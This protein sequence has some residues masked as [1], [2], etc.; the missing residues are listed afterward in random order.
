M[1]RNKS[2]EEKGM[3]RTKGEKTKSFN[4]GGMEGRNGEPT[5]V[6]ELIDMDEVYYQTGQ[7]MAPRY[8]QQTIS[9]EAT[10]NYQQFNQTV[11]VAKEKGSPILMKKKQSQDS[12]TKTNVKKPFNSREKQPYSQD[13]R[14]WKRKDLTKETVM[15]GTDRLV[16]MKDQRNKFP[17]FDKENRYQAAN[18]FELPAQ[19][20]NGIQSPEMR[21]EKCKQASNGSGESFKT[22]SRSFLQSKIL[23]SPK[24][25]QLVFSRV[26]EYQEENVVAVELRTLQESSVE[27]QNLNLHIQ[28]KLGENNSSLLKHEDDRSYIQRIKQIFKFDKGSI[29]QRGPGLTPVGEQPTQNY[30][31]SELYFHENQE[32][33]RKEK[34][35]PRPMARERISPREESKTSKLL[36]LYRACQNNH[37]TQERSEEISREV[38]QNVLLSNVGSAYSTLKENFGI[39]VT[40]VSRRTESFTKSSS[41]RDHT[42]KE[43]GSLDLGLGLKGLVTPKLT[44]QPFL[45][46]YGQTTEGRGSTGEKERKPYSQL[47][48]MSAGT[49]RRLREYQ[50]RQKKN[51]EAKEEESKEMAKCLSHK[52]LKRMQQN[53]KDL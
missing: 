30:F 29:S 45:T 10:N 36:S 43:K 46:A 15:S 12:I 1:I 9:E 6:T 48:E 51:T 3:N 13:L 22:S 42:D 27:R 38:E 34:T 44:K 17:S 37:R 31:S 52:T 16:A 11:R 8:A 26:D 49:L 2:K 25:K 5:V 53:C 18:R 40:G 32:Q 23:M 47:K 20:K 21:K 4:Q 14:N 35:S 39:K 41:H 7:V 28:K 33:E 24:L 19:L 50:E